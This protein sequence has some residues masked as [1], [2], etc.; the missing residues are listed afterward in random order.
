MPSHDDYD[1][2]LFDLGG[3]VIELGGMRDIVVFSGEQD[4]SEI[5]RRWL[6]CPWVQRF[7]RGECDARAFAEG[8]V[9]TWSM[10]VGPDEFIEAFASWPRGLL[11]GATD[12]VDHVA[13]KTRVAAL[14]NTNSLHEA[15]FREEFGLHAHFEAL[16]LSHE[17]GHV[18]PHREAFHHAVE[19][20][21]CTPERVLFLDDNQINVDAARDAG[22]RAELAVRVEGAREALAAHGFL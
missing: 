19:A 5:W 13:T 17:I 6:H 18:K 20:L 11:P 15:R 2:V 7:E 8:M 3:I 4:E 22:L 21:G 14:S 9:E 10:P 12:L 1:V 16:Y